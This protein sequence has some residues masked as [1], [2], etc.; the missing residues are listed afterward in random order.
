MYFD[1]PLKL[2]Y[3]NISLEER[4]DDKRR[5]DITRQ[6]YNIIMDNLDNVPSHFNKEFGTYDFTKDIGV[7]IIF[8]KFPPQTNRVIASYSSIDDI[9]YVNIGYNEQI[10]SLFLEKKYKEILKLNEST[11]IHE[12]THFL[13][14]HRLGALYS[15]HPAMSELKKVNTPAEFEAYFQAQASMFDK[16]VEKLKKVDNPLEEFYKEF[17]DDAYIFMERLWKHYRNK[18]PE[19]ADTIKDDPKYNGKWTKRLYQL[20]NELKDELMNG[21]SDA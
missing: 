3:E 9:I 18:F 7:K 20:Y 17:G 11:L 10:K 1:I 15:G 21:I 16:I 13:D 19:F 12:L 2:I 5:R 8:L 6:Y 4:A 14:F